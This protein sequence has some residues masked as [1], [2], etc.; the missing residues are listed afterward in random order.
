VTI[1]IIPQAAE[2]DVWHDH[3]F[4]ILDDRGESG[5]SGEPVVHVE[6]LTNGLTITNPADVAAYKEAFARLRQLAVIG[7][8]ALA[9]LRQIPASVE[10]PRSLRAAAL[11]PGSAVFARGRLP[12]LP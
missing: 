4:N 9:V 8:D 10:E 3:G 7:A 5:E 2:A 11:L 12:P 1:G 6:T